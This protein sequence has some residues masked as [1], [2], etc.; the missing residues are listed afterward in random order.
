MIY[1]NLLTLFSKINCLADNNQNEKIRD[2][3]KTIID[4]E[5]E[6]VQI[7]LKNFK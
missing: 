7:R 3:I 1:K 5:E 2:G 4:I 6:N